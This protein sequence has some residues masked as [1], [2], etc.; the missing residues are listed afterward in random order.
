MTNRTSLVNALSTHPGFRVAALV[1]LLALGG[2]ATASG[3]KPPGCPN[4]PISWTFMGTTSPAAIANDFPTTAYR[5]GVDGVTAQIFFNND[6]QG[7]RDAVLDLGGRSSTRTMSMQFPAPIADS[8]L[9]GQGVAPSFAGA[10]NF[11]QTKAFFNVHNILGRNTAGITPGQPATFYTKFTDPFPGP[12]GKD[13]KLVR[14]PFTCPDL[15]ICAY[16]GYDPYS[17]DPYLNMPVE[18]GWVKVTYTPR[19]ALGPACTATNTTNCDSWIVDGELDQRTTL[20]LKGK[21]GSQLH[22]GQYAMPFKIQITALAPLPSV[23]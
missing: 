5:N 12:D 13:Y 11:F 14:F 1:P 4:V 10:P 9:P 3:A 23:P 20:F 22:S 18:A 17:T 16:N 15:A 6:C 8:I 7:T 19:D 21:N 2:L